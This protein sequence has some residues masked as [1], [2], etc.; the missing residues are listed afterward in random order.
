[1]AKVLT[2]FHVNGVVDVKLGC[3]V[4]VDGFR[5]MTIGSEVELVK[6]DDPV[7]DRYPSLFKEF[8]DTLDG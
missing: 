2:G 6:L 3:F 4:V 8:G 5:L 1:M 7:D